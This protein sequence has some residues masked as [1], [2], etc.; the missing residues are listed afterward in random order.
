MK[1]WKYGTWKPCVVIERIASKRQV[2]LICEADGE[3]RQAHACFYR[4]EDAP[5][6]RAGDRGVLVFT[7][8][9]PTGGFWRWEPGDGLPQSHGDTEDTEHAGD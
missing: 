7:R 1:T 8:G 4:P 6:A 9:G 5:E 2:A 3:P